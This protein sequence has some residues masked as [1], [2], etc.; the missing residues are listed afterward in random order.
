MDLI[1]D[2]TRAVAAELSDAATPEDAYAPSVQRLLH[3]LRVHLDMDVAWTS[4]FVGAEQVFRFVDTAPGAVGPEPGVGLPLSGAYCAYVLAGKMP[5][6][7]PDARS[8]P[9][10]ALLDVTFDLS[11]GAY[12]GVPLAAPDGAVGGML[13]AVSRR[14]LPALD[15]RDLVSARLMAE[16]IDDLHR[17]A[18]GSSEVARRRA[19]LL[20]EVEQVCAG[21]GRRAV[22]Q[23]IVDVRTG[24]A[25][26]AEG[27]T[28]FT[29]TVRTPAE[30]F[31]VSDTVGLRRRLE[32]V[33]AHA[34]LATLGGSDPP[35]AI[36]VNLSPDLVADGCL[37][38]ILTGVDLSRVIVEVTE[39]A[40]VASYDALHSRLE[41]YRAGGLR[42]AVDDAGAGYSSLTHVLLL[43]PDII[44]I[45]MSLIRDI[46]TDQVRRSLVTAVA[47]FAR[48][49]GAE[50]VAEG[51]ET[52]SELEAIAATGVHYAQGYLFGQPTEHPSW[53]GYAAVASAPRVMPG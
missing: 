28:R 39:H 49:T 53:S 34:V 29:P 1:P 7:I 8:D 9:T 43:R 16:L 25:L 12:V 13:C 17:R 3:L 31:A 11:I 44:K 33:T 19:M 37:D 47:S 51:V 32:L 20:E 42:L 30:W 38:E 50:V 24:D 6:L 14:A 35:P 48:D 22:L 46:D 27:L 23:P 21:H 36:S 2:A 45:D 41:P 26:A 10:A 52:P 15:E 5:S 18:L 4:E 40:R